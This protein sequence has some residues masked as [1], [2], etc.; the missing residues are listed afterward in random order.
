MTRLVCALLHDSQHFGHAMIP[1]CMAKFTILMAMVAIMSFG[2]HSIF[3]CICN[4]T[5]TL[6]AQI[7]KKFKILKF[8]SELEIF[9]RATHQTPIFV[10]NSGGQDWKFQAILKFSSEIENFKRSWFFSRFG[11]LGN[12]QKNPRVRKIRVRDSG[13]GNGCANF[14]D[15]WKNAF[16]LQE[17]PCP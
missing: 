9:K 2:G 10:G 4:V 6:R 17:N 8:S 15:T 11:P 16:F 1:A 7:L 13:A 3:L 14:M 5:L 12:S